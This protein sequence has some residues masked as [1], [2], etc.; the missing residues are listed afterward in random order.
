MNKKE[1]ALIIKLSTLTKLT[2]KDLNELINRKN[3]KEAQQEIYDILIED[4]INH[5]KSLL[6]NYCK[7]CIDDN[8]S[9]DKMIDDLSK[10][11]SKVEMKIDLAKAIYMINNSK[12]INQIIMNYI[13]TD[14]KSY[15]LENLLSFKTL[16][17]NF[18]EGYCDINDINIID[19]TMDNSVLPDTTTSYLQSLPKEILTREQ[20]RELFLKYQNGD[21]DAKDILIEH[22]LRL[23]V[24]IAVRCDKNIFHLE[25]MDLIQNGNIGLI[26][27]IERFDINMGC[28]L[29]TYATW[30]IR[31]TIKRG[32]DN[33]ERVIR[34]PIH[35]L[36]KIN[37][38]KK[39]YAD[40]SNKYNR[41][42]TE[43][44]MFEN[45]NVSEEMF[46]KVKKY[47]DD[48]ISLDIPVGE[49]EHGEQAM[50][51][52]FIEQ[53]TFPNPETYG[54]NNNLKSEFNKVL[55]EISKSNK[56]LTNRNIEVLKLRNGFYNETIYTLEEV[57]LVLD[58]VLE[59]KAK[60]YSE[61][62]VSN[63]ILNITQPDNR[64]TRERIRQLES[65]EMD[66][67][68]SNPKIREIAK[69][70]GIEV[71]EPIKNNEKE[72]KNPYSSYYY[73][74]RINKNH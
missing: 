59:L 53:T 37:H 60:G 8:D 27:A 18:I 55:N 69:S 36:E 7:Y 64:L 56:Q 54:I 73:R 20:E 14:I 58:K 16:K 43:Q 40:F 15:S 3:F 6:N 21:M 28:K 4:A 31:Q 67:L 57:S 70:M 45:M 65:K 10:F 72:N 61:A 42:P 44:E 62:Q 38:Y 52:D 5:P 50:L 1:K 47:M 25:L 12:K 22:N 71:D 46:I 33:D 41:T 2:D 34:M 66:K 39:V 68:K 17:A 24:S 11:S 30:W 26:K 23:V 51:G 74:K 35:L 9:F 19:D 63:E 29:S 32:I 49:S 48:A 13:G